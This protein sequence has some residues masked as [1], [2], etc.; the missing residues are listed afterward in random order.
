M[1]TKRLLRV[2]GVLFVALTLAA[3]PFLGAC[4][5]EEVA[6]PPPPPEEEEGPPPPPEVKTLKIGLTLPLNVGWGVAAKE[7]WE[8]IIP[9]FNEAGGLV[10]NGQRYNVEVIIYD[11]KYNP[12][13]GVA[14]VERM[15]HV[16]GVTHIVG[17]C[18]S[19][20]VYASLSVTEPLKVIIFTQCM[21]DKILDPEY[22]YIVR[23]GPAG[24]SFPVL[25][26]YLAKTYPE[27]KTAVQIAPDNETGKADAERGGGL[28][29]A[30]GIEVI[31][32]L[33]YPL[34]TADFSPLATKAKSLNPDM[35]SFNATGGGTD[36]GL[37]CKALDEAGWTG[38]KWNTQ[39]ITIS[40]VKAAATDAQLEG[41]LGQ[42]MPHELED[43]P[44]PT[45]QVKNAYVKKYG[46]WSEK[47]LDW[48]NA[49]FV[50]LAA[51]KKADSLDSDDIMAAL[52][53][54]ELEGLRGPAMMVKRPDFGVNR[55]VDYL[56]TMHF[57]IFHNG[58]YVYASSASLE[59]G[60]NACKTY[61][62]GEPWR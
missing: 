29:E 45:M 18:A 1:K 62:G 44:E 34:G 37:L 52:E 42:I 40:E 16:D 55:C 10:V 14:A 39:T 4:A 6:P 61:F 43:P 8:A 48:V 17:M 2:V 26:G 54:L 33:F 59:E 24:T 21:T 36:L 51:V 38:V 20:V 56:A 12:D 23:T 30:F 35:V 47:G 3:L 58:E 15:I 22:R 57:G 27:V 5:P 49:W 53:G 19:P 11:D 9:A 31:D 46:T 60:L 25:Y 7:T 32:T 28:L 13:V 50:F 41:L